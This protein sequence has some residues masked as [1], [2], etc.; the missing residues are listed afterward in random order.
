M[1]LVV[2][3]GPALIQKSTLQGQTVCDHGV[4]PRAHPGLNGLIK[5]L[6]LLKEVNNYPS[7]QRAKQSTAYTNSQGNFLA[8][9]SI[10]EGLSSNFLNVEAF[11]ALITVINLPNFTGRAVRDSTRLVLYNLSSW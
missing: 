8:F 6:S 1:L 2:D 5:A 3:L 4:G 9:V 7:D 10:A 11:L